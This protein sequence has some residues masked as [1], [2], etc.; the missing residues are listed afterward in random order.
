[1]RAVGYVRVSSEQQAEGF[2]LG[3]QRSEIARYCQRE[4]W[5]LERYYADEGA[6]AY[7]DDISKRPQ[8]Q[9]L[10]DAVSRAEFDVVVVH[11]LDRWARK[12]AVQS[13]TLER[14]GKAGIGFVSIAEGHDFTSPSG[15]L[16]LTVMGGVN[17]FQSAQTA[18]HVNKAQR[19]RAELGLPVG[20]VPFGYVIPEPGAA[21]LIDPVNG[22]AVVE[23]FERRESGEGHSAVAESFNAR[24]LVTTRGNAFT[25]YSIRDLYRTRFYLGVVSYKGQEYP[26]QHESLIDEGLFQRVQLQR[27]R[28]EPRSRRGVAILR[29]LIRCSRCDR[30][31]Y[32]DHHHT[33]RVLYRERHMRDCVTEGVSVR[34][35]VIDE[36]IRRI[37]AAIDVPAESKSTA[38]KLAKGDGGLDIARLQERRK[39]LARAYGDGA[40]TEDEYT[41]RLAEIDAQLR[42]VVP[43]D[44]NAVAMS[45]ELVTRMDL[46]WNEATPKERARVVSTLI[47]TAYVDMREAT[48]GAI[49]PRPG[50]RA[51]LETS[52]SSKTPR[53]VSN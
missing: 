15:R 28:R 41:A 47:D 49:V 12:A 34:A 3:A 50:F 27:P 43:V 33:G 52:S 38:L 53:R 5:A 46:I 23:A 9:A 22:P 14:L 1:M 51:L 16:L 10:L 2:S 21:P 17:E 13:P 25:G 31:V 20:G 30:P 42:A 29:G 32:P 18:L 35:E 39:R 48:V 44:I 24:G 8:F 36:Q 4:G 6:S 11:T 7:T 45:R 19:Q 26:G 40:Y 37:I